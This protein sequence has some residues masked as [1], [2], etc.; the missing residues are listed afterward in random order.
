MGEIIVT[1]S[2]TLNPGDLDW[3]AFNSLGEIKVYERT[4]IDQVVDR[5]RNAEIVITNKTPIS[6]ILIDTADKLKIIAVTAT[7]YNVVDVSRAK[8]KGIIVCNVP[9]YG[10]DSVAQHTF[11]LI[12]ELANHVGRNSESVNAGDWSKSKDWCYTTSPI[13]EIA[14][15]ILGLV[16]YGRIGQKVAKIAEA[17]GM[18]IIY[19]N[20]SSKTGIGTQV[21]LHE[22]F[23]QSDFISLHLPLKDDNAKFVNNAL[24]SLM[25]SSGFL[26]NTSR[27]QLIH[28][29]DLAEAIKSNKIAGAALDVLSSEPP[30]FDNPLIGL[31]NCIITPHNAWLSF[32]ARKRIMDT[33]FNNVM[34]ALNGKPQNVI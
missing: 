31:K 25:K 32:E 14:G 7:G 30:T 10:T 34:L 29:A 1:D 3:S 13:I 19:C 5:C 17:F 22:V 21:S 15:K 8:Q 24:F 23:K 20:P 2:Y 28:E 9:A 12:L 26:I 33:T 16:G 6:S 4:A 18:K 11:A 27:G